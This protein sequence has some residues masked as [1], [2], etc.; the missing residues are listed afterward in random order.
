M[1]KMVPPRLVVPAIMAVGGTALAIGLW[2]GAGWGAGLS[3][4]IVTL[5]ATVGYFVLGSR[6]SDVGALAGGQP[7][8]RQ[9]GISARAT[10]L[11]ANVLV[12]VALVG[13]VVSA[14][15]GA[16]VW[17]FLLFSVVAGVTYLVGLLIY[18]RS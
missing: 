1:I 12:V 10:V 14:A 9:V 5:A 3:V 6:D 7:D 18:R 2:I 15:A 4:E 16:L 11:T 17:P 8:E 13:V